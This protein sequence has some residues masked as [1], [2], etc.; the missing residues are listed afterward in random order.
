[1][2]TV[3]S[4]EV[5][6]QAAMDDDDFR[7]EIAQLEARS[8]ALSV[9]IARCVKI[10]LASKL[11]IAAGAI[12]IALVLLLVIPYIPETVVAAMAAVIGGVV[13]LGSNSSTWKQ[14]EADLRNAEATRADLI[15]R[16]DLRLIG[17]QKRTFH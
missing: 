6:I 1:M 14:A 8:E 2:T 7:N 10:S 3:Q 12:W 9:S 5:H 13:L 4:G 17:E 11:A 16:M 15:G